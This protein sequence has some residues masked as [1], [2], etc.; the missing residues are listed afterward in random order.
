LFENVILKTKCG[1]YLDFYRGHA[2]ALENDISS[3]STPDKD[4]I[5]EHRLKLLPAQK[6]DT[7]KLLDHEKGSEKECKSLGDSQAVSLPGD[8]VRRGP[9]NPWIF[10]L[11]NPEG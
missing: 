2:D 3:F 11:E 7:L 8:I 10:S 6:D 1:I 5:E 4:C 9:V